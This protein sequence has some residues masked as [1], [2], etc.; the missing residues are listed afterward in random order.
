[1]SDKKASCPKV[2][3]QLKANK[4]DFCKKFSEQSMITFPYSLCLKTFA[5]KYDRYSYNGVCTTASN[6]SNKLSRTRHCTEYSNR[7][8]SYL[9][10]CNSFCFLCI[11][12][13]LLM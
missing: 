8:F 11:L 2:H 9:S 4:L 6:V 13:A 10:V 5:L 1:M 3:V 12:K 7:I